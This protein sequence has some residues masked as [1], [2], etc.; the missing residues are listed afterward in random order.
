MTLNKIKYILF[1]IF[2]IAGISS[3]GQSD[4]D[5]KKG[6]LAMNTF[7][8]AEKN[9][10]L[11]N[12]PE[13]IKLYEKTLTID[14][15]YD[16]AMFELARLYLYEQK[17]T[18]A[19]LWAEKAYELDQENKWYALLI[20]DLYRN[21]YQIKDAIK[22][23]DQLLVNDQNN[24]EYLLNV[25]GLYQGIEDYKNSLKYLEKVENLDGINEKTSLRKRNI[26]LK[27]EKSDKAME[28]MI[29]LSNAFPNEEK[30]CS[31][32]AELYMQNKEMEKALEW[33]EKVL[34]INPNNPYIQ[35]TLADYYT[36]QNEIDKAYS[37]LKEGYANPH[38]DI[39]TKVQVL[40][41]YF[42]KRSAET[43]N[44]P[45]FSELAKILTNTHPN[46]AK[47]HAIYADFLFQDSLYKEA[48]I[49]FKKV[50]TLDSSRYE[51]WH[52][53]LYSLSMN[54]ENKE[55]V[56]YS[57]RT[58]QLFPEMEFPYYLNA[59]ANFQ[60]GNTKDVISTLEKG[61]FFVT[62]DKLLEQF[63]MFLGDAY[64]EDK[65]SKKAYDSYDKC[66]SINPKNSFVLNNYA[67]YLSNEG[68]QLEK[69][70]KMAALA[71]E[72]DPNVNNL[73]TYG[74]VLFMLGEYND[75]QK[76]ILQSLE[77]EKVPSAVVLEHM[78]DVYY[79][80]DN[81]KK[82]KSYWKKAKKAGGE[83]EIL[84]KKIKDGKWY[85]EI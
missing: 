49:E 11:D 7:L 79:K 18:E 70:K 80:L 21:N 17:F 28:T 74:W 5:D 59:L 39:D 45:H 37:Y 42:D 78:G 67:Y 55:L 24:T 83:S 3:F 12:Y 35:I 31:M 56:N 57:D 19:L 73:D 23:Y 2:I 26:Y 25:S 64:H 51:V 50:I 36:K 20:I 68:K 76:Y 65:N 72:T 16:P 29:E 61:L 75:A 63:Y 38:L 53:L 27:Q 1:S 32:I 82:A 81:T 34:S 41:S 48:S 66:L 62:D 30:Y 4:E 54:N 58:I 22:V 46:E 69:A 10:M 43:L 9:K 47:A 60:E 85:E 6:K 52:Q 71:V 44:K 13:A 8:D 84:L 77:M 33:Y 15:E 14:D 40:I